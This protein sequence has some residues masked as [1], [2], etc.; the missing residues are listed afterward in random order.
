MNAAL[1]NM[2]FFMG[3]QFTPWAYCKVFFFLITQT[4]VLGIF[5]QAT[6]FVGEGGEFDS[7]ESIHV[8]RVC[9]KG[10]I[11]MVFGHG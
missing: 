5:L 6:R 3:M 10:V 11:E 8:I 9:L 1:P 2:H 4:L 7:I